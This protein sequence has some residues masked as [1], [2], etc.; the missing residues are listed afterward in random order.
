VEFVVAALLKETDTIPIVFTVVVD[1]VGS[2]FVQSFARPG[3]N[4]TGF[5]N[6][7]FTMVGKWA[8]IFQEIA[9]QVRRIAF[10]YNPTTTPPGWLR[11]LDIITPSS[12]VQ[13][14]RAPVHDPAEIDATLAA[15]ARE[16]GAGFVVLP[17]I[18]LIDN[19][20]QIIALAG[21]Y[22]LPAIYP[23]VG[24][25]WTNGLIAYGPE[26]ADEFYRAAGY[27]DRILKARSRPTFRFR[28]RINTQW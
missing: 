18:F 12:S 5:Q 22:G 19:R 1:P 14:V 13:L 24:G 4:V 10:I 6:F 7:E 26:T 11:S 8:Q 28:R 16:P 2:G 23:G 3:G 25:F 9:P 15:L 17:D 21:K 27:V 20:A